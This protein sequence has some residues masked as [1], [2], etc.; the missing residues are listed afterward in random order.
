ME[1]RLLLLEISS[2]VFVIST[3]IGQST[4]TKEDFPERSFS[5]LNRQKWF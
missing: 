4:V 1:Q 5:G 3:C 2:I